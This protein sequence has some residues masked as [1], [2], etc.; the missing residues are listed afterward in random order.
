[1]LDTVEHLV[2]LQAQVP[3]DPYVA[4]WTRLEGFAP[5]EL[6]AALAERRA[7]R[8]GLMRGTLHLVSARDLH[9]IQPLTMPVFHGI[10]RSQFAKALQAPLQDVV[11]AGRELLAEEP[12]TR[13]Q[14]AALLGPRWPGT[15][16]AILA[17]A[18][19]HHVPLV[20]IPP[21]GLWGASGQP[22]W[23]LASDWV[24]GEPDGDA[25]ELVLRYL[26]AFGPA[27]AADVRT[28]SRLTGLREVIARLRPRLRTF[29]DEQGRELLD[30]PDGPLP[31]P[32]TPAPPRFLPQYDNAGL[33]HAD[34]TRILDGTGVDVPFPSGSHVGT[35]LVDG[36]HRCPWK[37]EEGE[38]RLIGFR[39]L[40][41]EGGEV[42]EAVRAEA[43]A[44]AA[45]LA[46]A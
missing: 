27:T 22:T 36:F 4:L 29:A 6:S 20:Q 28:W 45:F 11:Q 33:S 3:S 46:S 15:D 44:L 30:V 8:A 16:P 9:R 38:V 39:L 2:G 40:P 1:V 19:V 10:F 42:E 21:R 23:A 12:R 5:Q 32:A 24:E 34:R 18:V 41:G 25:E 43:A 17:H 26:A 35:L 37:L 14:L 31:D 7:V 13:A